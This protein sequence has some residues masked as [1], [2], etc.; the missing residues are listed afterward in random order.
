M[1]NKFFFSYLRILA[2]GN[3]FD[4]IQKNKTTSILE[5]IVNSPFWYCKFIFKILFKT[6]S[7]NN[8]QSMF[9]E[10]RSKL[11]LFKE[12]LYFILKILI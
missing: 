6:S 8:S 9:P 1:L 12:F 7:S 5:I 11:K 2:S 3:S 4:A 10:Q